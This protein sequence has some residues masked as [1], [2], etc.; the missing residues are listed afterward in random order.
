M[1]LLELRLKDSRIEISVEILSKSHLYLLW[2]AVFPLFVLKI[3]GRGGSTQ[4]S[5]LPNHHAYRRNS[6]SWEFF[7]ISNSFLGTTLRCSISG[8][9]YFINECC[10]FVYHHYQNNKPTNINNKIMICKISTPIILGLVEFESKF[11]FWELNIRKS[12]IILHILNL[13]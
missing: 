5:Q 9:G 12:I 13:L 3:L 4:K 10:L 6:L 8:N 11:I 2:D 7:W 1:S